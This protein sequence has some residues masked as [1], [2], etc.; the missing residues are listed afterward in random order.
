MRLESESLT[1]VS[2]REF[3][4]F[5]KARKCSFHQSS[6]QFLDYHISK[7]SIQMDKGKVEAVKNW[8]IPTTI[9]ELQCFLWF[10]NFYQCFIQNYIFLTS[11]LTNLLQN[12][13]KFMLWTPASTEAFHKLKT[14][15]TC[16]LLLVHSDTSKTF[17]VE[18]DASTTRV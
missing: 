5:L 2:L 9:K 14:A 6:V 1:R 12:K 4:P 18:V 8:P 11:P 13:P 3:H 10:A 7:H 15:F 17:I 16:T